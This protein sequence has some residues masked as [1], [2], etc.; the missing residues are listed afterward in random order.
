MTIASRT[1]DPRK[2]EPA[3]PPDGWVIRPPDFVVAGAP[4]CGTTRW[5]RLL[6]E[7]PDVH[8][9]HRPRGSGE[10]H[11]FD[12]FYDHWP[13]AEDIDR[14]HRFFPR[15]PGA[16]A[17]DKAPTDMSNHWVP[18]M[19]ADGAPDARLLV[20]VRDPV[21]RFMSS[22][23]FSE[24]W[25]DVTVGRG[26]TSATFS[27]FA[28]TR[29]FAHGQ[30][31]TQMRWLMTAFPRDRILVQQFERCI[32]DPIGQLADAF[33]F[34]GISPF[35]PS[36]EAIDRRVNA[37]KVSRVDVDPRHREVL[38][39]AFRPEV[40]ALRELVPDLDLSLWPNFADLA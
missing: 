39:S 24:N 18:R 3:P 32:A 33:A 23:T 11:F 9:T 38:R 1:V 2:V 34:L 27:R 30:Y 21:E 17:G 35:Q 37:T 10:L 28:V 36:Q 40:M 7:H 31:A 5:F 12:D 26:R 25:R 22:R 16:I 13:T 19:L 14:Y 29:S 15:P 4:K 8:R 6:V 20:L